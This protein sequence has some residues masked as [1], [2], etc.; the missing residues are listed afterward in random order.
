MGAKIKGKKVQ[1]H[2]DCVCGLNYIYEA[3]F[4]VRWKDLPK[5]GIAH[6]LCKS[7]GE[8]FFLQETKSKECHCYDNDY[9]L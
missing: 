8:R 7:T 1:V 4:Q 6:K 9:E 5:L 3:T 2:F